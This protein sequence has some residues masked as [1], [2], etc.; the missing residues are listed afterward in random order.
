[1]HFP[2]TALTYTYIFPLKIVFPTFPFMTAYKK[3]S[4]GPVQFCSLFL[5]LKATCPIIFTLKQKVRGDLKACS[6]RAFSSL[7]FP[8]ALNW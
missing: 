3:R 6:D 5:F 8:L 1:M 4:S 7:G 2:I